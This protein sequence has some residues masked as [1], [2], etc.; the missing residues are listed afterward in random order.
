MD[1]EPLDRADS[2]KNTH[3]EEAARNSSN[4]A[5]V[6][7]SN[8]EISPMSISHVP[9]THLKARKIARQVLYSGISLVVMYAGPSRA[10]AQDDHS[11]TQPSQQQQELTAEQESRQSALIRIVREATERFQDV[12]DAE[13]EGYHLEFGCVSGDDFGAMGLH[14]V[15]DALVGHGIVDATRPQIV[16]YEAQRNGRLKLTGADYLVLAE[17]WDAKHPGVTPQLMGQIFHYFSSPN[18]FGLPAFY[19]LHVWAWKENP[20]GAF[21]NWHPNVSCQSFVGK[22]TP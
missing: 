12:R 9:I 16:L 7:V 6:S 5:S 15:N 11:H 20:K 18:R 19:T 2:S 4:G 22:T 14:Y 1:D 17:E 21:V 8:K 3:A 13:N 10:L